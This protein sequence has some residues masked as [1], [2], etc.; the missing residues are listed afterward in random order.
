MT[1]GLPSPPSVEE[2]LALLTRVRCA[3]VATGELDQ[4]RVYDLRAFK[5]CAVALAYLHRLAG[6]GRCG[7][8]VV[9][10]MHQLVAGLAALHPCWTLSGDRRQDRDRHR[11]SVGSQL[12]ALDAAGVLRWQVSVDAGQE[13]HHTELVLLPVPELLPGELAAAAVQLAHWEARYGREL[14]TG[15]RMG[16]ADVARLAPPLVW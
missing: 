4:C 15:A 8:T 6:S 5:S 12:S 11:R 1:P 14:N 2:L 7:A 3:R 10:S 9:T 13:Q 16:I